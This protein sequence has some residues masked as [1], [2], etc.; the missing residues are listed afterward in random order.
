[1]SVF[2]LDKPVTYLGTAYKRPDGVVM[3]SGGRLG[4]GA[5]MRLDM[6]QV[7]GYPRG[8]FAIFQA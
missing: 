3:E 6:M 2:P 4:H 1:M 5:E 7:S 8:A